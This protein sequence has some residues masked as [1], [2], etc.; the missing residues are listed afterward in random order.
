MSTTPT[1]T[2]RI[3]LETKYGKTMSSKPQTNGTTA[4]CFF[5][6]KKKPNPTELKSKPQS[7]DDVFIT[8]QH[9]EER[10][11]AQRMFLR[12]TANVAVS[13]LQEVFSEAPTYLLC[14]IER[15][16]EIRFGYCMITGSQ[17]GIPLVVI[18]DR[19]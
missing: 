14:Q 17:C 9:H 5:P 13:L 1:A 11:F 18:Y 15:L 19:L 7:S 4:F 12:F 8:G 16:Q 3:V 6:Y 10:S 2:S